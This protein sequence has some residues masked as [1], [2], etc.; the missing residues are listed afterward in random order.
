MSRHSYY[1]PGQRYNCTCTH[2]RKEKETS[3]RLQVS[4]FGHEQ[5]KLCVKLTN[6][7]SV[8]RFFNI[9]EAVFLDIGRPNTTHLPRDD[10]ES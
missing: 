3:E 7:V 9:V 5:V 8:I 10:A 1:Q 6:M 4:F 2:E